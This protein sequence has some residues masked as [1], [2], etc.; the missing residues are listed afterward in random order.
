MEHPV[1]RRRR[2][3]RTMLLYMISH[4]GCK[5]TLKIRMVRVF[6]SWEALKKGILATQVTEYTRSDGTKFK[7]LNCNVYE[8]DTEV[9]KPPRKITRMVEDE[10]G[11]S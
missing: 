3:R 1:E 7:Y 5:S 2:N 4:S 11:L 6:E 8:I 9:D 10:L